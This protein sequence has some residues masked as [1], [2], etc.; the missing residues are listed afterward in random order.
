MEEL[1]SIDQ[2]RSS[3]NWPLAK[4]FQRHSNAETGFNS[5]N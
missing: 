5:K 3:A 4:I 2:N 1:F